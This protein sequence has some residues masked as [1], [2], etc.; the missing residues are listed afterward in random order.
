MKKDRIVF[1]HR[2]RTVEVYSDDGAW[3][4]AIQGEKEPRGPFKTPGSAVQACIEATEKQ[5]HIRKRQEKKSPGRQ[6][7]HLQDMLRKA[8]K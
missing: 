2:S 5:A 3:R 8:A 1:R 6:S 4:G 7:G